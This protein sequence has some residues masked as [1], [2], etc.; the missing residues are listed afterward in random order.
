MNSSPSHV[1]S[2]ARWLTLA[3]LLGALAATPAPAADASVQW[4]GSLYPSPARP[5]EASTLLLEAKI[6]EGYHLYSMTRIEPGPLPLTVQLEAQGLHFEGDWFAPGPHVE[7]DP[8]FGKAVES[9]AGSV[10]HS[11]CARVAPDLGAGPAHA[12]LEVKGQICNDVQCVPL[13][14]T[15]E[16]SFQVEAAPVRPDRTVCPALAG[17]RFGPS[18]K[19][20]QSGSGKSATMPLGQGLF[21]FLFIAFLAGLGALVTPCVFP[22]IP[23]TVSFFSKFSKVSLRRS[24]S[25][26]F[27]YALSIVFTFT[28]VGVAVSALF[29]AVGMQALSA[30]PWFNLFLTGLLIV[31]AFNLF[32]LFEI[33]VPSALISR[34]SQKERELSAD[35][36]SLLRQAAGIFFMAVTFTLISFT[37]TV[38]FIGVVLAEAAKGH[39][40]YP[41]LGML[42]FSLAFSLPFFF[43]AVFPSWADKLRGKSGDWMVAIK[44]VLGFFEF[45]GA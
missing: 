5:G 11:A 41:A 25:M 33:Q 16:I 2:A 6:P 8:N 39:W 42:F 4:S 32:G 13:K 40:F 22:M 29:G 21:S 30:S 20:P 9:Y 31:F 26:A 43:L 12:R 3:L 24:L 28:L 7:Q 15:V 23:I 44:A 34:S 45:A 38:G 1:F 36:G 14:Q 37:C 18:R 10:T 17:E 35:E 27:L 19:A